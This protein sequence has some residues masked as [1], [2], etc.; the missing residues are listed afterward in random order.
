MNVFHCPVCGSRCNHLGYSDGSETLEECPVCSWNH[1]FSCGDYRQHVG[2]K[3]FMTGYGNDP[4]LRDRLRNLLDDSIKDWRSVIGLG[5]E[6]FHGFRRGI[7]D[8]PRDF[9]LVAVFSDWLEERGAVWLAQW[10]RS[11]ILQGTLK[12][13]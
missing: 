8:N 11:R 2:E 13:T 10:H 6:E 3:W 5:T 1:R 9:A 12:R 4:G 7:Q